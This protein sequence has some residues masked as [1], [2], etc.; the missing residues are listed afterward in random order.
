M[1]V[2]GGR[3]RGGILCQ[4]KTHFHNKGSVWICPTI[5]GRDVGDATLPYSIDQLLDCFREEGMQLANTLAESSSALWEFMPSS[6]AL[7]FLGPL[8]SL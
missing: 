1:R 2:N 4:D 8:K 5:I 3:P 6:L 7:G